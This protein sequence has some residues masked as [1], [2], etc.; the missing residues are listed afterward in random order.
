MNLVTA[1]LQFG[2]KMGLKQASLMSFKALKV[3]IKGKIVGQPLAVDHQD[4]HDFITV[5][6]II[7]F[8]VKIVSDYT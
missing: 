5:I 7:I 1:S 4:F 2:F 3:S 6:T 8:V